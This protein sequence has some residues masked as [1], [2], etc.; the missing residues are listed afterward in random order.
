MY[1]SVTKNVVFKINT[2]R[3][4]ESP[5]QKY[6]EIETDPTHRFTNKLLFQ[7]LFTERT[8]PLYC[9]LLNILSYVNRGT[10]TNIQSNSTLV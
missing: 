5:N 6:G 9:G 10:S 1:F 2:K 3:L 7:P 4:G 8:H